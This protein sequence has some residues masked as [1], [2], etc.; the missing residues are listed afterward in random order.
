M[1]LGHELGHFRESIILRGAKKIDP[2]E[3]LEKKMS[4]KRYEGIAQGSE[5]P[6][7]K[8]KEKGKDKSKDKDKGKGKGKGKAG[9]SEEQREPGAVGGG[10]THND[11]SA[12][13]EEG[14]STYNDVGS[15]NGRSARPREVDHYGFLYSMSEA[16]MH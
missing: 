3:E 11:V 8:G 7:S 2:D 12:N 15:G 10:A 16:D 6:L 14:W 5:K 1:E 13:G 4:L 9:S